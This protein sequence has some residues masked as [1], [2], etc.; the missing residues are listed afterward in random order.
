MR[1]PRSAV[2]ALLGACLLAG[3][4]VAPADEAV[5]LPLRIDFEDVEPGRPLRPEWIEKHFGPLQWSHL[6]GR[7]IFVP[8]ADGAALRVD[9]PAGGYRSK[10]SSAQFVTD[11]P[12]AGEGFLRYRVRFSADFPFRKGGKLPGLA[13]GGSRFTG[14]RKPDAGGGWSA[15]YMWRRR[16]ELELYLYHPD[17]PGEW[18]HRHPLGLRAEPGRWYELAQHVVVNDPGEANGVID[19]WVDGRHQLRVDGL[20]LRGTERGLA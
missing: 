7:A 13:G 5:R 16:G 1:F 8:A 10:T 15:R 4:F 20:R 14:G 12:P 2:L 11:L 18:G 3:A 6:E 17:M 19:V 9:Y